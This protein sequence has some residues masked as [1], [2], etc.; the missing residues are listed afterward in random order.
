MYKRIAVESLGRSGSGMLFN[1]LQ[2]N[3]KH[4]SH[5][6]L[7]KLLRDT[8]RNNKPITHV[9]FT[10]ASPVD[11]VL[12]LFDI[13]KTG[14]IIPGT[15]IGGKQFLEAHAKN[16]G[17][18]G[19]TTQELVRKIFFKDI[20]GFEAMFDHYYQNHKNIEIPHACIRY[21][22]IWDYHKEMEDFIGVK[23]KLPEYKERRAKHYAS[24]KQL[25]YTLNKTYS[26]LIN[27]IENAEPWKVFKNASS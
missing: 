25:V 16:F 15:N 8:S 14:R 12:S 17:I 9:I 11:I 2:T 20:F 24:N 18:E 22:N 1:A 3:N 23:I 4:K 6:Y 27:K 7:H 19:Y 26:S 10:Y 13:G 5:V 21:K